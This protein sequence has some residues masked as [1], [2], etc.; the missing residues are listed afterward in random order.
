MASTQHQKK[1]RDKNRL[2]RSQLNVV[3]RRAVH[4]ELD[5]FSERY[6]LRGK[7][8]AVSFATF[9]TR[10]LVQRADFSTEAARM[11]DD[12]IEAYHRDRNVHGN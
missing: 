7:G 5:R 4:N 8:E 3:A 1:W 12:F 9:V 11:L 6:Q 2:V 10:A